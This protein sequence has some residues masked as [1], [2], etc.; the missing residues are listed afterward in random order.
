MDQEIS[1]HKEPTTTHGVKFDCKKS[2]KKEV[3]DERE[4]IT[5]FKIVKVK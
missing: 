2:G 1:H 3:D 4:K 5:A